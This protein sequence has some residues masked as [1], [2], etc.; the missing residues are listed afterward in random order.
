[1]KAEEK[2]DR[3][4]FAKIDEEPVI[5]GFQAEN[6]AF[7]RSTL[8]GIEHAEPQLISPGSYRYNL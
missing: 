8:D 5:L 7:V 1:M 3:L 4:K 6:K 2:L